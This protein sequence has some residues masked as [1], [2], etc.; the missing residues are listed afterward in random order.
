MATGKVQHLG[1]KDIRP[2]Q[3]EALHTDVAIDIDRVRAFTAIKGVAPDVIAGQIEPIVTRA[4]DQ[5]VIAAA[6]GQ[7]VI[8]RTA[9]QR[10]IAASTGQRVI[11]ALTF[12]QV[13]IRGAGDVVVV[14]GAEKMGHLRSHST[15]KMQ[16]VLN[17]LRTGL[18]QENSRQESPSR[19]S[20]RPGPDHA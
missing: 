13:S 6:P 20:F 14:C 12:D 19:P 3:Q 15:K 7:P 17:T 2:G 18:P 4:A 10:V 16:T 5:Q 8:A 11:A 9:V 1:R